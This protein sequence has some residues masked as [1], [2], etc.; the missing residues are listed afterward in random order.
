MK[1]VRLEE[2]SKKDILN[3]LLKRSP[4]HYGSYMEQVQKIVD[5]VKEKGDEALFFYTK[6]FDGFSLDEETIKVTEEE[7]KKAYE[8]IDPSLLDIMQKADSI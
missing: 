4:N 1:I 5:E 3:Q 6:K 8:E 2:E 7:I